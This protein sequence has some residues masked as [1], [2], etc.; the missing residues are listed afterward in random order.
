MFPGFVSIFAFFSV[1][2]K[3]QVLVPC[4]IKDFWQKVLVARQNIFIVQQN[5]TTCFGTLD[6]PLSP[7]YPELIMTIS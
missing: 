1:L 3:L 4:T 2:R 5:V 6:K 7:R